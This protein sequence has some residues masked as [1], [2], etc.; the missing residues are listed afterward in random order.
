MREACP[1]KLSSCQK[2]IQNLVQIEVRCAFVS[3]YELRSSIHR[4]LRS[5]RE[6]AGTWFRGAQNGLRSTAEVQL[7][8][9]MT[10]SKQRT[11]LDVHL[12]TCD[13]PQWTINNSCAG[14]VLAMCICDENHSYFV[15]DFRENLSENFAWRSKMYFG[16]IVSKGTILSRSLNKRSWSIFRPSLTTGLIWSI[17][18]FFATATQNFEP[19]ASSVTYSSDSSHVLFVCFS[20]PTH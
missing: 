18:Q 15:P 20:S 19:Q 9:T 1:Q 11:I 8:L 16:P 4:Q 7:F 10:W 14:H 6:L 2:E 5:T 3:H 17:F 13:K 12:A